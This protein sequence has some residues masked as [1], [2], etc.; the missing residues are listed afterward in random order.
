MSGIREL[1]FSPYVIRTERL[2]LRC[3]NPADAF[4]L[5]TAIAESLPELLPWIPWAPNEPESL[6]AKIDRLRRM[7]GAFDLDQD[8]S[9]GV[10]APD[11]SAVLGGAGLHPRVGPGAFEIGY[12]IHSAHH[13]K[14]YATECVAALTRV[15]FEFHRVDRVEIHCDPENAASAAVARKLGFAHEATLQ[16]RFTNPAG[17]PR[18]TML[19]SLFASDYREAA[20]SKAKIEAFDAIGRPMLGIAGA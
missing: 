19:W 16:R 11:D 3:F 9:H 15:A 2:L 8:Y 12:W 17:R 6:D 18:D 10:F 13:G 5:Q 20:A 14:G 4:L 1:Q 7:R